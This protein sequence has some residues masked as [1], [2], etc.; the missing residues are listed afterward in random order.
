MK[1]VRKCTM[2]HMT[3]HLKCSYKIHL[4]IQS[5]VSVVGSLNDDVSTVAVI[6]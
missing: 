6:Q 4:Y 5:S 2:S 3:M 1:G